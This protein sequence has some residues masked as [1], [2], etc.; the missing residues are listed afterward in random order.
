MFKVRDLVWGC[1]FREGTR[2]LSGTVIQQNDNIL[3]QVFIINWNTTWDQH[4]NQL[5]TRIE[6][7]PEPNTNQVPEASQETEQ[8]SSDA[9]SLNTDLCTRARQPFLVT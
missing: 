1:S 5:H 8:S 4:A 6:W 9:T 7:V 3:Y 2:W